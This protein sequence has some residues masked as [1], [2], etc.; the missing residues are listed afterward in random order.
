MN[1]QTM[2]VI[3]QQCNSHRVSFFIQNIPTHVFGFFSFS[4]FS[5]C[6]CLFIWLFNVYQA[7]DGAFVAV[8][9]VNITIRDVNNHAPKFGRDNYMATIAEDTP[10]GK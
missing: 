10:I 7:D 6:C 1:V 4:L 8:C 2:F 9:N 3:E 5:R